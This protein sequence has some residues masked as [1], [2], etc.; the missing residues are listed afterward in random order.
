MFKTTCSYCG[1][2]CGVL[3]E[4]GPRG[5]EVRGDPDHPVNSG[6][7]FSKGLKLHQTVIDRGDLLLH[8]MMSPSRGAPLARVS[9]DAAIERTASVFRSVIQRHGPEAVALYV[10]GQLLTEEYYLVNRIAKGHIGTAN[11]DTNSR[12]CMSS[13]VTA[14]RLTLG[15]DSVP[16]AYADLEAADCFLVAGANPAWCHPILFGRLEERLRNHPDARLIVVDPRRTDTAERAHLHLQVRPGTDIVLFNA[17]ARVLIES[18]KVDAG[19]I[20]RHTIGFEDLREV[21][22]ELSLEEAA[23][24]TGVPAADIVLAAR[25]IGQAQAFLSLWAMG[26]NQSSEGVRKNVAL[27]NLNLITGQIGRPGAGPFSLTGQPNAMGGREVGGLANMLAAHRALENEQ[28]R[29]EVAHHWGVSP[30]VIPVRSGLTA[31]EM[32][33]ALADD[34]VRAIWIICTNPTVSMPDLHRVEESL[35]R[36]RFVAVSEISSRSD[37]VSFADVVFPAAGW[38][39]KEGTMTNSERRVAYLPRV[40]EAPGEALSDFEILRRFGARM[41]FPG[42]AELTPAYAFAE[43]AAL[44][45][46]TNLDISGL[47]HERLEREGSVQ[48]PAPSADHPGTERLFTD[49][50]FHT[51]D[52]RARLGISRTR[53]PSEPTDPDFPFVLT[54][55]RIRDQWHTMTRT[56]KVA[57][58][59]LHAPQPFVEIHPEDARSLAIADGSP[60]EVRGRRGSFVGQA[61]LTDAIRPGVLFAPMHWGRLAGGADSRANNVTNPKFDPESKEPDFKF[62]AVAVRPLAQAARRVAVVG[63]GTAARAFVSALLERGG[64][65]Q[66][67]VFGEE[68]KPFYN[69]ILLPEY[70]S[71]QRALPGLEGE[72]PAEDRLAV[73]S[74]ERVVS[75][76]PAA[77]TLELAS[78]RTFDYDCLVLAT[79]GRPRHSALLSRMVPEGKGFVLRSIEDADRILAGAG[80]RV[81]IAGGGLLGVELADALRRAGRKVTLA[82]RSARLMSRQLDA[83]AADLLAAELERRG[84]DLYLGNEIVG[85]GQ[86]DGELVA[87]MAG[88]ERVYCSSV[89]AALG[90]DPAIE[91]AQAGGLLTNYGIIVDARMRTSAPDVFAIGE[92]VEFENKTFGTS[93]A[94]EE[95]ARVLAASLSGDAGAV[96][97]GSAEVNVLK[98]EGLQLAAFGSP[99]PRP[100]DEVVLESYPAVGRYTR[101]V[102]RNNRL[103]GGILLGDLSRLGQLQEL[104]ATGLEL[105]ARRTELLGGGAGGPAV[106]GALVCSCRRVGQGNITEAVRSGCTDIGD[107]MRQTGAGHGCGSCRHEVARIVRNATQEALPA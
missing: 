63:S 85:V 25:W 53:G 70:I 47:S 18:G 35:R 106:L 48:W 20:D 12:L 102:V 96:Y 59:G 4:D 103:V 29:R 27:I 68:T 45:K 16:I 11:I 78:G 32:F 107:V 97:G 82:H 65:E 83:T 60:V 2:G 87:Y 3:V 79:G 92:C 66:I 23:V 5:L 76:D 75:F 10:S 51:A 61:R 98:V 43:H 46:G 69:R 8:P 57:R 72:R 42:I 99:T 105:D 17:I 15:E 94:A 36:A 26:L 30:E 21:V 1:V 80:E 37:T 93:S 39:E 9:W 22:F 95:Q 104:F 6:A 86:M 38:L 74:G 91:L 100:D 7:L 52:G 41:G 62:S 55:G 24:Q 56:G 58:L 71:G 84:I 14:Q 31:V 49:G 77:R 73:I 44:T 33:E 50:R 90:T 54:T 40:V 101:L 89:V 81:L 13:A 88:G 67:L 34:R 19:F 64:P 28:H